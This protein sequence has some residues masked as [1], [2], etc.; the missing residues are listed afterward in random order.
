MST[1][2]TDRQTDRQRNSSLE[3]LRVL[4]IF[5]IISMHSFGPFLSNCSGINL[6]YGT[7]INSVFNMGVTI[8]MLITGYF[9]TQFSK[10]VVRIE[11]MMWEYGLLSVV[12]TV[13]ISHYIPWKEL[14]MS[15][16]PVATNKYWYITSYILIVCLSGFIN[17]IS[18]KL[19]RKQMLGLLF[20]LIVFFYIMPSFIIK[21]ILGDNGKG[22]INMFIVYLIGRYIRKYHDDDKSVK[23][24]LLLSVIPIAICFVGNLAMSLLFYKG[25]G[26][27]GL[28]GR[29]NSIF[30]LAGATLIFVAFN[31][32]V[33]Y[34]KKINTVASCV[35]GA[36]LFEGT[37]RLV[38][39]NYLNWKL[40]ETS[41]FLWIICI[42]YSLIVLLICIVI[43]Y[44]RNVCI[45]N[46]E[47]RIS[48]IVAELCNK[49]LGQVKE[50]LKNYIA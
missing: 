33:F 20:I 12:I 47:T 28:L 17:K 44:I 13:L 50:R 49:L 48:D 38:L 7:F 29:D 39:N 19:D 32:C 34:S 24:L 31:N 1:I 41:D 4:C 26:F 8:F 15:I 37:V 46:I 45:K 27:M 35:L 9:G 22:C 36:Y 43:E 11:L 21:E 25:H 2:L 14:Y 18:E 30:I 16:F 5:G 6:V 23:K 40:Y 3:L 10:K 42:L